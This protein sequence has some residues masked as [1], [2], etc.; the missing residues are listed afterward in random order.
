MRLQL[1]FLAARFAAPWLYERALCE[2]S[3]DGFVSLDLLWVEPLV[4]QLRP[5]FLAQVGC[6]VFLLAVFAIRLEALFAAP[7]ELLG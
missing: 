2:C 4:L 5:R 6:S 1:A 3:F 7:I